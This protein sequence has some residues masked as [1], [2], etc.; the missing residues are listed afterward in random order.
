LH[1]HPRPRPARGCF[2]IIAVAVLCCVA[3]PSSA[4]IFYVRVGGSDTATGTSPAEGFATIGRAAAA[5]GNTPGDEVIVGPGMYPEGNIEPLKS[6]IPGHPVVFLADPTGTSTGDSPGPVT[7]MPPDTLTTTTGFIL[8]GK[9]DVVIDGFTIVGAV[10]AGIQVRAANPA[11]GGENSGSVT[12]QNNT[13]MNGVKRGIDVTAGGNVVI[14]GNVTTSNGTAGIAAASA[15]S[16]AVLTVSNNQTIGNGSNGIFVDGAGAGGVLV[17]SA[18]EADN[19]GSGG[20][21]DG[22]LVEGFEADGSAVTV[23]DNTLHSNAGNGVAIRQSANV[24]VTGNTIDANGGTGVDA[25]AN[26]AAQARHNTITHSGATGLS[27]QSAGETLA[28]DVSNNAVAISGAHGIFVA[29]MSSGAVQNN[30]SVSNVVTGI[31]LR[32]ATNPLVVN[33]LVYLNGGDGLGIGTA[34][35]AAPNAV[36]LNNTVYRN[37]GWGLVIG[38]DVSPSPNGMVLDNIFEGNASGGITVAGSSTCGYIAGFNLNRDGYQ[39]PDTPQ[40]AY[41]ITTT[42]ARFV[43]PA[44]PDGVLGGDKFADDNFRLQQGRGGQL[45]QSPAVDAGFT[46][47]ATV[48]LTGSTASG[49]PPDIGAIDIGYH[50]GAAA[51][52]HIHVPTPYMPFFVRPNGNDD[53]DGRDPRQALA[54]IQEGA[55]RGRA[56]GTVVVGPGHYLEGDIH[57]VQ[58]AGRLTFFADASGMATGD[59][60]GVVLVDAVDQCHARDSQALVRCDTGFVALDSCF[61]VIDG[62]HITGAAQAAIQ[63]R[64]GSDDAQVRNN[65]VFS[66]QR[67]GIE[68]FRDEKPGFGTADRA[69]V[70]NNL[71]YVNGTGGI[72]VFA[73]QNSVVINNT[74]YDNGAADPNSVGILIGGSA[75]ADAAPGTSVLRNIVAG[76]P[77]GIKAESNSLTGYVTGFNV[78]AVPDGDPSSAFAGDSPRADSDFLA[79]PLF[80][81]PSGLDGILGGAGFL[82][83]DFHLQQSTHATSPAVDIDFD[84]QNELASGSTRSDGAPDLGPLDS[85]YHSPFLPRSATVQSVDKVLFVRAGGSDTNRGTTPDRALASIGKALS[86]GS[87]STLIVV[88]PGDYH[89]GRLRLGGAD[90]DAALPVL[91]G[92]GTGALS[93]DSPGDVVIDS[94]STLTVSGPAL[95]DG[96]RLSGAHGAGLRVLHR[97]HEVTVRNSTVCGNGGSGIVSLGDGVNLT[98]NLVC[99]NAREGIS[100]RLRRARHPAR[101]LNNTIAENARQGIVVRELAS[102]QSHVQLYNNVISGNGAAGITARAVRGGVAG[103]G[104]NLNTDGYGRGT[105]PGTGD[106][107]TDAQFAGGTASPSLGCGRAGDFLVAATSPVIDAGTGTAI[108][109][110]LGNR[111]VRRDGNADAGPSDLGFHYLGA[112]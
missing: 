88:G 54:T 95:I 22:I 62:F 89:E 103:A 51:D 47:T 16:G 2:G 55:K 39:L 50:Y 67:R 53:N 59:L 45:I 92:D 106:V 73:S 105:A 1:Q 40:N 108:E 61:V 24:T 48:G 58:K 38:N 74:V 28:V 56:G 91:L 42:E 32:A 37:G 93:G 44:G 79:D 78:V 90:A 49:D 57:P 98:N 102:L 33:N 15:D 14:E 101:V 112:E 77:K 97:A 63:V 27:I 36:I 19:N 23:A 60:P 109:I 94:T 100:M 66:N 21:G 29:G 41:D 20:I 11:S 64:S 65:V 7:I 85:G 26:G 70:R 110:G 83:D 9:H 82:D 81:N 71:V 72:R 87:G 99:S 34:E 46:A 76:N 18:N 68:V 96:I 69:D 30:V 10:D 75:D 43:D 4:T 17:V 35:T 111:S 13:V 25:T 31:T 8:F 84:V 3:R 107:T 86:L 12:I 6:G 52:Q 5:V 104:N 80:V